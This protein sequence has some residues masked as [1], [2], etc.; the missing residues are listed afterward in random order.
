MLTCPEVAPR[1]H[2]DDLDCVDDVQRV[3]VARRGCV[4]RVQRRAAYA[5]RGRVRA[6]PPGALEVFAGG[7]GEEGSAL[8][9]P[10]RDEQCMWCGEGCEREEERARGGGVLRRVR[11]RVVFVEEYYVCVWY[12]LVSVSV[13][14]CTF[15]GEGMIHTASTPCFA[16]RPMST[17]NTQ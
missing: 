9:A 10:M 15:D 5:G 11:E 1:P 14:Q 6:D 17:L 13:S 8:F 12:E 7:H 4:A 16:R 3:V 2:G